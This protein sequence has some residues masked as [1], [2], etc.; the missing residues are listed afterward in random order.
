[1]V[2]FGRNCNII[3]SPR[4]IILSLVYPIHSYIPLSHSSL[5]AG[6]IESMPFVEALRQLQL[7]VP[8]EDFCLV[9]VSMVPSA[10]PPPGEQK[11]KPTQ[12]SVKGAATLLQQ[13]DFEGGVIVCR[14]AGVVSGRIIA[15]GDH[16]DV[17]GQICGVKCCICGLS[18]TPM[19]SWLCPN[20]FAH[21]KTLF[22]TPFNPDLF[23]AFACMDHCFKSPPLAAPFYVQNRATLVGAGT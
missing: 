15:S 12:H 20:H 2:P 9:H 4:Y 6:D 3:H 5:P 11:T 23:C 17:V 22:L 8:R 10:G 1:M 13:V 21:R 14:G 16:I 19:C 7:R 18:I